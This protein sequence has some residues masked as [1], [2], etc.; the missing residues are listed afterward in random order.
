MHAN[1]VKF[2][3][4]LWSAADQLWANLLLKSHEYSPP[5]LGLIFLRFADV[6]FAVAHRA[7]LGVLNI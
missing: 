2:E 3:K 4:T 7:C 6:N 5:V 1:L